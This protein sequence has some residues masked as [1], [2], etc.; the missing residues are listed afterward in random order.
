MGHKS[1]YTPIIVLASAGAEALRGMGG[2]KAPDHTTAKGDR[3][4]RGEK[5]E[6]T[7]PILQ[8]RGKLAEITGGFATRPRIS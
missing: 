2:R 5:K 6:Y 7:A 8:K 3:E 4:R 1:G